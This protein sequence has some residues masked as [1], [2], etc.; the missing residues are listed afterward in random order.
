MKYV[1]IMGL[2]LVAAL[3]LSVVA[4]TAASARPYGI[5]KDGTEEAAIGY[6]YKGKNSVEKSNW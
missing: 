3:A 4:A 2:C 5:Y 1:K 6:K